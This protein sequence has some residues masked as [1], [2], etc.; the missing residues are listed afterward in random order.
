MVLSQ[1]YLTDHF[2]VIYYI[3]SSLVLPGLSLWLMPKEPLRS[4]LREI[5][6]NVAESE[7]S[8]KF[9]P[10]MTIISLHSPG[11][12]PKLA[13]TLA[14]IMQKYKDLTL[15]P[16]LLFIGS[17]YF[18]SVALSLRKEA[19]LLAFQREVLDAL[20]AVTGETIPPNDFFPHISLFY[21]ETSTEE[22]ERIASFVRSKGVASD[23][24]GASVD[25]I[26]ETIPGEIWVV[27]TVG[28]TEDWKVVEIISWSSDENETG[29]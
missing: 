12:I 24:S 6:E 4:K 26:T 28:K 27:E 22:R 16:N 5:I 20:P 2:Y 14:P 10:H 15:H 9:E 29:I 18:V 1:S 25:G 11:S 17:S 23:E 13:D 3:I 19:L 7:T 8:P 21:G